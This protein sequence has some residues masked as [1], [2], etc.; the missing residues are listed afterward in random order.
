MVELYVYPKKMPFH[1]L[2]E[3]IEE[4]YDLYWNIEINKQKPKQKTQE[5]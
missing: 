2:V 4:V 1:G 5:K 3:L